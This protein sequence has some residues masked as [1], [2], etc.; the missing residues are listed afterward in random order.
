MVTN[1]SVSERGQRS[2]ISVVGN[3]CR[4]PSP[5][6]ESDGMALTHTTLLIIFNHTTS[7]KLNRSVTSAGSKVFRKS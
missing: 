3:I 1:G 2:Q 5:Q 6:M 7:T 4:L